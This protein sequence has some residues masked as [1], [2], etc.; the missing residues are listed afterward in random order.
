MELDI[1]QTVIV[2]ILVLFVGKYLT[3]KV[4][5]LQEYH[6]PEPVSGGLIAS[7][8]FAILY[9]AFDIEL[10]FSL[11]VRDTLLIVFFTIIGLSSRFATLLKGRVVSK[12]DGSCTLFCV[13]NIAGCKGIR[14][15]LL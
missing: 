15:M 12:R 2:A 11:A 1:R 6:I 13:V 10:Q 14:S 3:R 7:I 8:L 9:G 4:A 5:F